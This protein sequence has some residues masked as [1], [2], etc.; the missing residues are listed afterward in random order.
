LEWSNIKKQYFY[1]L[2]GGS[3]IHEGPDI[4]EKFTLGQS[5]WLESLQ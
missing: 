4:L 3:K 2:G 5:E 1:I